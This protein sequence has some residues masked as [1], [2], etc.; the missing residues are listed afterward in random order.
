MHCELVVPALLSS[1]TTLRPP[2]LELLLARGRR[3][4]DASHRLE[5]W[6][7]DAFELGDEPLAAGALTLAAAGIDPGDADWLRADPVHLR[8]MRDRLLLAPPDAIGVSADEA[9]AL[10]ESLN[11]HFAGAMELKVVQPHR[12]CARLDKPIHHNSDAPLDVVGRE[13]ELARDRDPLL[14]EIQMLLH[15]HPVNA[16]REGRGEPAIN[17][18]WLWGAGR[19][20]KVTSRWATVLADEPLARGLARTARAGHGMLPPSADAWLERGPEDGRILIVLDALRA[21]AVLGETAAFEEKL[22]AM[23]AAWFAPLLTALRTQR[24]GMVTLHVPDAAEG[25]SCEAV[26]GDLRRI[27]RRPKALESYA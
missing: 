14:N 5:A 17:S 3:H 27:W 25:V 15:S 20:P 26:R 16:A 6:L 7:A 22:R 10:S 12:W 18:L 9:A 13:V 4:N 1:P 23:E 8:I 19:A 2:A 11:R 24:I 21:P